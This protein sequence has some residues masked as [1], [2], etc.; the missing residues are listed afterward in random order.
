[1]DFSIFLISSYGWLKSDDTSYHEDY[2]YYKV[3]S[4][5]AVDEKVL[6]KELAKRNIR[7]N[8]AVNRGSVENPHSLE[9]LEEIKDNMVLTDSDFD[10][11][12]ERTL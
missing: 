10:F 4:P 5:F 11:G 3:N 6:K 12:K 8:S 2:D 7:T 9:K 1:M